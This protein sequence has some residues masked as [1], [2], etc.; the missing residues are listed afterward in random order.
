MNC[1]DS[2]AN[3]M[4][5]INCRRLTSWHQYPLQLV[6]WALVSSGRQQLFAWHTSCAALRLPFLCRHCDLKG[7]NEVVLGLGT[8][9]ARTTRWN[10]VYKCIDHYTAK[11]EGLCGETYLPSPAPQLWFHCR[12]RHHHAFQ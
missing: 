12:S 11:V 7:T 3:S 9:W 8:G 1:I 5:H 6:L 2:M 10:P 4:G